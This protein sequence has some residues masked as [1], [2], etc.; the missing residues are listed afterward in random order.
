MMTIARFA[1]IRAS[2]NWTARLTQ[3]KVSAIS[4]TRSQ[5]RVSIPDSACNGCSASIVTASPTT[6]TPAQAEPAL[7][8]SSISAALRLNTFIMANA[9]PAPSPSHSAS[10]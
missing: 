3:N 10:V 2:P 7:I 5:A 6:A 4:A 1:A 8:A 9:M